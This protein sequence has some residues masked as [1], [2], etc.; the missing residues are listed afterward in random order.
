METR[1]FSSLFNSNHFCDSAGLY[2]KTECC[3]KTAY[4]EIA[5]K[6]AVGTM[7]ESAKQMVSNDLK[8]YKVSTV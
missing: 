4:L 2:I 1:L 8:L 5:K 6:G 7:K 3:R